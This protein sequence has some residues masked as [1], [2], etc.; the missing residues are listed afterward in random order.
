MVASIKTLYDLLAEFLRERA[1]G[2][3]EVFENYSTPLYEG[4]KKV[5]DDY[6]AVFAD[7]KK[8]AQKDKSLQKLADFI[9]ERRH[10]T[11][12][13]RHQLRAFIHEFITILMRSWSTTTPEPKRR[14]LGL[15]G[16]RAPIS[17]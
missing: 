12:S 16:S 7:M 5:F 2:K 13:T 6:L 15:S 4:A 14:Y 17:L 11:L 3:R 8:M 1:H 9:D 10:A